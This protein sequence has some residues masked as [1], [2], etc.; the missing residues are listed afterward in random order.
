MIIYDI[1]IQQPKKSK[2]TI[3]EAR[4]KL[5]LSVLIALILILAFYLIFK[6]EGV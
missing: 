3:L 5:F 1:D 6:V 2:K 4:L